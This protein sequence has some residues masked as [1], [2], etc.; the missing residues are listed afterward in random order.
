MSGSVRR[1]F[2][3]IALCAVISPPNNAMKAAEPKTLAES[4]IFHVPF[5]GSMDA[6]KAADGR[7]YTGDG[8]ERKNI[9]PGN[10][11]KD[12]SLIP[13]GRYGQAVRFADVSQQVVFFR[14]QNAGFSKNNW[15]G[16]VSFWL[17]ADPEK[18]L[19]PG[20]CDPIQI[21]DKAWNDSGMWVDFDKDPPRAFRLGMFSKMSVW[22]PDNIP[23]E[24]FP[25]ANRPMI[26][27]TK[28]AFNGR[29][30]THVAFTY[31]N[32]NATD[33]SDA[34]VSLYL[35]G[36]HQGSLKRPLKF[37]WD[38]EKTAIMLG[39]S[40]VGDFDDLA[41]FSRALSENEV[42]AVRTL[43]AGISGLFE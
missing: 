15:S 18:G 2:L 19:K 12:V 7:L 10:L 25:V 11:R 40:Y 37:E 38:E 33:G 4:V 26:P 36:I 8:T 42:E 28:P 32:V 24:Q 23:W 5:D 30:W 1:D 43:P 16:T 20:Y 34:H 39:L 14:G 13:D 21:T 35:H 27:V 22:N 29:L 31:Q 3:L 9:Q 6:V 41:I 17:R